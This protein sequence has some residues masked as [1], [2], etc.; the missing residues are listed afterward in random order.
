MRSG[1]EQT[2]ARC[3]SGSP[4]RAGGR[5][6]APLSLWS[7]ENPGNVFWGAHVRLC[8]PPGVRDLGWGE[9]GWHTGMGFGMDKCSA[10]HR[11]SGNLGFIGPQ[12]LCEPAGNILGC[13][14]EGWEP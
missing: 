11:S 13:V 1:T 2:S 4:G 5:G 7:E 8:S 14:G 9:G 6:A 10:H 3:S 12:E